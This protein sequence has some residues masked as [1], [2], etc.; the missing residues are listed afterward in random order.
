MGFKFNARKTTQLGLTQSNL[1]ISTLNNSNVHYTQC[2]GFG[3]AM[4]IDSLFPVVVQ[5]RDGDIQIWQK[6]TKIERESA[7]FIHE[8]EPQ[9]DATDNIYEVRAFDIETSQQWMLPQH[10]LP[11]LR[12]KFSH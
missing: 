11:F 3:P 4:R 12:Q 9:F 10:S 5:C 1:R 8:P 6:P 7:K 2:C